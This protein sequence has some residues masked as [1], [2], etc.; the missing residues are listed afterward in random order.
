MLRVFARGAVDRRALVVSWILVL[1]G[2]MMP[3]FMFVSGDSPEDRELVEM[4]E[5][6]ELFA[7]ARICCV[8]DAMS[9]E[10]RSELVGILQELWPV[11]VEMRTY[12]REGLE[13]MRRALIGHLCGA[14]G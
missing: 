11:L 1:W 12:D 5:T 4:L 6:N 14:E 10:A 3:G 7:W 9:L 8:L 13:V 2:G